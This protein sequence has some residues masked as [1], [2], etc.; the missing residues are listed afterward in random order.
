MSETFQRSY[1][2]FQSWQGAV[3]TIDESEL[4]FVPCVFVHRPHL[5][6][7]KCL[8]CLARIPLLNKPQILLKK[9]Y[10]CQQCHY[11]LCSRDCMKL[12]LRLETQKHHLVFCRV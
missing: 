8:V 12:F 5:V 10:K 7:Q 6:L 3:F 4:R 2:S 9:H 1:G 11:V